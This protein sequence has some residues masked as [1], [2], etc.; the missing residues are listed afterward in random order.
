MI[1]AL[2][3]IVVIG[4]IN[5]GGIGAIFENSKNIPGFLEFFG[6]ATPTL[7]EAGKLVNAQTLERPIDISITKNVVQLWIVVA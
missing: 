4:V 2:V 5:A 3:V 7:N 1:T 6:M